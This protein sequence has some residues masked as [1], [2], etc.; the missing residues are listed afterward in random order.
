MAIM[1][2]NKLIA[3]RD[4]RGMRPL[5]LG[6]I[7]D[8]CWVV[9]SET[10]V[11]DGIGAQ[12]LRDV[13]PGEVVMIDDDGI[14]SDRRHCGKEKQALCIY[15][16]VY[17][18]RPDSVINGKSVHEVR[19]EIGKLLAREHPV[20]ADIV[21]GVPDS[22]IS[23]AIGYSQASG[24]PYGT[25]LIKNKYI[26]QGHIGKDDES[27]KM[28]LNVKLNVLESIIKGKRVILIDDS[29]IKGMTAKHIIGLLRKAGATEIH[30][31][32]SSPPVFNTCYFGTTINDRGSLITNSMKVEQICSAIGADSLGFVSVDGIHN[33]AGMGEIGICDACFTGHYPMQ[34]EEREYFNK[35]DFKIG[36]QPNV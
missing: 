28:A 25:A 13:E 22:G 12:F 29:I 30:M 5:S 15:E 27:F 4:P 9:A 23:A 35:Y 33:V 34:V 8:D 21:C 20:E 31:R 26:S 2:R 24:I 17:F 7:G 18:A 1:S 32:I 14:H 16:Y 6:K 3:V 36:E 11:F 10:C 19:M